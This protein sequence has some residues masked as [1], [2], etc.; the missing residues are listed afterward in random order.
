ME[1]N[2][3]VY[4]KP[5]DAEVEYLEST[6]TQYIDTGIYGSNNSKVEVDLQ[7]LELGESKAVFG[8]YSATNIGLYLY[9]AGGSSVGKWQFGFGWNANN[10]TTDTN[11]HF[12]VFD[13]FKVKIDGTIILSVTPR[14]FTTTHT[15]L[16]FNMHNNSG[17]IYS[18]TGMRL[19][20]CK[21]YNGDTL[22][23]DLIPVRVGT[24]GYM[25]DKVSGKLFAN[26]GTG[27]FILGPDV[28]NPVPNLRR[29]FRFV[30]KRFVIPMPYDSRVEYLEVGNTANC[31]ID[32]G[33]LPSNSISI[34]A[35][36]QV[37]D[38][39]AG[40]L[41][42]GGNSSISAELG[43]LLKGNDS[44]V[45]FRYGNKNA[46]SKQITFPSEPFIISSLDNP[47]T[48]V[49]NGTKFYAAANTFSSQNSIYLFG[50]HR[51]NLSSGRTK[52]SR[53]YYFKMYDSGTLVRDF[54]PVRKNGIGY[55]YDRV[56]C[57][58]FGNSGTGNFILGNDIND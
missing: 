48:L 1:H 14:N 24:V 45:S 39:Y 38:N 32:T 13:N 12:F 55:M 43:F 29:V 16:M 26:K 2:R 15:L 19:F 4:E 44:E 54:I 56:S 31:Y 18:A 3:I 37:L 33:I 6:G 57:R 10:G 58:L 23:R 20:S 25:Y 8:C 22:V 9:Q 49:V 27:N 50:Q 7:L 41:F 28:A 34:V 53:V 35:Q 17:G 42:E 36:I 11:R 46:S 5:Y 52:N 40:F 51:N 21:L 30:N 47:R